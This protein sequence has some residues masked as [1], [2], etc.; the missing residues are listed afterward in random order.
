VK[1]VFGVEKPSRRSQEP[2]GILKLDK[3]THFTNLIHGI[4]QEFEE[5]SKGGKEGGDC[6][7]TER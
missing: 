1:S 7:E 2:A 4:S 6:Q 5:F 3:G